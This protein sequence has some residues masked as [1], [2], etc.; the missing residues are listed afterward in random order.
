LIRNRRELSFS[1]NRDKYFLEVKAVFEGNRAFKCACFLAE[2]F[3]VESESSLGRNDPS[4]F[5]ICNIFVFEVDNWNYSLDLF[6]FR[7][8]SSES[9]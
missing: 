3:D 8:I 7:L 1:K 4:G 9:G 5:A 6:N 2:K